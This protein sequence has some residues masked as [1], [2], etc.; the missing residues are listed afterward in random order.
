MNQSENHDTLQLLPYERRQLASDFLSRGQL[1][2]FISREE[3]SSKGGIYPLVI[4]L[5]R[6]DVRA[7]LPSHSSNRR[8]NII[9]YQFYPGDILTLGAVE[10]EPEI[11]S[12]ISHSNG[13]AVIV[14]SNVI[15]RSYALSSALKNQYK[16]HS[17]AVSRRLMDVAG[18]T[19]MPSLARYI[20]E[21][22]DDNGVARIAPKGDLAHK[23]D[24]TRECISRSFLRLKDSSVVTEIKRGTLNIN[25]FV[26]LESIASG[27]SVV[28]AGINVDNN[29]NSIAFEHGD[30]RAIG[31]SSESDRPAILVPPIPND[32][33]EGQWGL[34]SPKPK[35]P[36][37]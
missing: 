33:D 29:C 1:R 5:L 37:S 10:N 12:T 36:R 11:F 31:V 6:G 21:M 3:L 8:P 13:L 15:M 9:L 28:D 34:S 32:G 18:K 20:I 17:I 35:R 19:I 14:A 4:M 16:L 2:S 27:C 24:V 7:Y 22:A 23:F 25:S 30:T 26:A